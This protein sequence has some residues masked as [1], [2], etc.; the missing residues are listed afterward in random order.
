MQTPSRAAGHRIIPLMVV[1]LAL[2][3]VLS[4]VDRGAIGIAAPLMTRSLGLTTLQFG[5]AASAFFW[6]YGL[7]QPFIG[8]LAD[9]WSAGRVLAVS[10]ALWAMATLLTSLV[11]G[12]AMLWL[13]PRIESDTAL[14]RTIWLMIFAGGVG[15][16]M[17][18]NSVPKQFLP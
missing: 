12:L 4:Y 10:I 8:M 7:A 18:F 17:L 11:A 9:R 1:L 6:T 13:I 16:R 15:S 2:A 3:V 5:V 14:F